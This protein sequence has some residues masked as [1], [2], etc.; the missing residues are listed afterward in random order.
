MYVYFLLKPIR[1]FMMQTSYLAT[2]INILTRIS[3]FVVP[4]FYNLQLRCTS[5]IIILYQMHPFF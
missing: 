2:S 3:N 4:I 5:T 1:T